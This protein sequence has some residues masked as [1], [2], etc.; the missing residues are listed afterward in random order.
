MESVVVNDGL[1]DAFARAAKTAAGASRTDP[2]EL[3]GVAAK[4]L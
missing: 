4:A 2:M 1:C 3:V